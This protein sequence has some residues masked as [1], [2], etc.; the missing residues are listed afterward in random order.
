MLENNRIPLIF[1]LLGLIT[2]VPLYAQ[3]AYL[4]P[5]DI[6]DQ[7][8]QVQNDAQSAQRYESQRQWIYPDEVSE[9]NYQQKSRGNGSYSVKKHKPE[10]YSA[11]QNNKRSNYPRSDHYKYDDFSPEI[12]LDPSKSR[13][14]QSKTPSYNQSQ[15]QFETQSYYKSAPE[16]QYKVE[17]Q[18]QSEPVYQSQSQRQPQPQPQPQ[19]QSEPEY[20]SYQEPPKEL[21]VSDLIN[22]P[23]GQSR[24]FFP[25]KNAPVPYGKSVQKRMEQ[26]ANNI[27]QRV[28]Q[29]QTQIRY[30]PVPV[31]SYGV[32]GTL[33]G[34]IP[35]VVTPP[36]MVPGYSHLA[37]AYSNYGLTQYPAMPYSPY[38]QQTLPMV[39]PNTMFY[40]TYG[41]NSG[42]Y[43]PYNPV[44]TFPGISTL[45]NIFSK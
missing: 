1:F 26:T 10:Y 40:K 18:Y 29:T 3:S 16:R 31:Y 23:A 25:E 15:G 41:N 4:F 5:S 32:P 14:E 44:N 38:G 39:N 34:T 20:R 9:Q 11:E 45:P 27:N 8:E 43:I 21:Y 36:S 22:K 42:G 2:S 30:I 19:P 12:Y 28:Q 17:Q 6:L 37:P 35:G 13:V 33:P 24:R 7:S